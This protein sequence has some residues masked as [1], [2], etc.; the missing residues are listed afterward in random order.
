MYRLEELTHFA[1]Q[2]RPPSC[3]NGHFEAET[4]TMPTIRV[5]AVHTQRREDVRVE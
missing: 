3:S 4:M 5:A 1:Q 2:C